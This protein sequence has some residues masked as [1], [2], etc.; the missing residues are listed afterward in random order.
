MIPAMR[1]RNE[2]AEATR[3]SYRG[4]GGG[5]IPGGGGGGGGSKPLCTALVG[6]GDEYEGLIY[7]LAPRM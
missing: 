4:G 5:G 7:W 3:G 1:N 6:E 2:V